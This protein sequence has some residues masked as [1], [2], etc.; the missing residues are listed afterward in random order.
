MPTLPKAP[1]YTARGQACGS[2][3]SG[4]DDRITDCAWLKNV[5]TEPLREEEGP[6]RP[7]A[8]L[9][10]TRCCECSIAF[11]MHQERMPSPA[12]SCARGRPPVLDG[13]C[14]QKECGRGVE[15]GPQAKPCPHQRRCRTITR[16]P[17]RG[18]PHKPGHARR[19]SGGG[20]RTH[21]T[22]AQC[23]AMAACSVK[24]YMEAGALNAAAAAIR[25]RAMAKQV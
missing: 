4:G 11:L 10:V 20:M 6:G 12:A 16:R 24:C 17:A 3:I 22:S 13:A 14:R 9:G 19:H 23:H 15:G 8:L 21:T 7:I 18:A 5:R 2:S 1:N 25:S